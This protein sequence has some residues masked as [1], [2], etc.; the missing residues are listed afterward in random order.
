M[1]SWIWRHLPFGKPGRIVGSLVLVAALGAALWYGV[2]PRIEQYVPGTDGQVTSGNGDGDAVN[3]SSDPSLPPPDVIPYS[4][5]SN[6]PDPS[7]TR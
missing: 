4:T 7:A 3:P 2:F 6:N 1:Y 5:V